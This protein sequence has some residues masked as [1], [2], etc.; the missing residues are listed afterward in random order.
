M[1]KYSHLMK[2][3]ASS[4]IRNELKSQDKLI[5]SGTIQDPNEKKLTPSKAKSR[6]SPARGGARYSP[7]KNSVSLLNLQP[8]DKRFD[9]D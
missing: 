2:V 4:A 3:T 5:L 6:Y 8:L 7:M 1:N 9:L